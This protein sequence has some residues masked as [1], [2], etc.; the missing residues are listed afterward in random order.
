MGVA[1]GVDSH[2]RSLGVAA[3]DH[4]G[5]VVGVR[6]FANDIRGHRALHAWVTSQGDDRA[7]GIE[8]A[9]NYGFALSQLLVAAGEEVNEVPAFMTHRERNKSPARGK[10][11]A[12]DAVA[13]ARIVAR[14]ERLPR[15]ATNGVWADLKLLSDR[16][17]QL[18]R[19]RTGVAN[20]VHAD[21]VVLHPGYAARI[22]NLT[23]NKHL[24]AAVGLIRG[25]RSVRADIVRDRIN[26]LRSLDRKITG[27]T[28]QLATKVIAS[29]TTLTEI[30][31]IGFVTAARILAE[32]GDVSRFRSSAAFAMFNG[33]APLEASSGNIKRHRLNR[34]GNRQLNRALHVI[35]LVRSHRDADTKAYLSRQKTEGK[36]SRE[37]LRSLKRHLSNVVYR[38]LMGDVGAAGIA[39]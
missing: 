23:A 28:E 1:I 11:D 8:G 4:L 12:S 27:V 26:E 33:T 10:S 16:R 6:E 38:H 14:G 13:I 37:A 18:I 21:L 35:A 29:G 30:K 24:A 22:P 32:A 19:H 31:G 25:D 20:Q 3:V 2:K 36:T 17:D 5:R 34:G 7:I 9:G 39:A 15:V